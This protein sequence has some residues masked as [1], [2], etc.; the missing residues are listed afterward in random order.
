M[1]NNEI[2]KVQRYCA[3]NTDIGEEYA[4]TGF[5]SLQSVLEEDNLRRILEELQV[6]INDKIPSGQVPKTQAYFDVVGDPNSLKQIQNLDKHSQYFKDLAGPM[7]FQAIAESLMGEKATLVNLQY[8]NK[9]PKTSKETPPH[10]DG[11]YFHIKPNKAITMWLSLDFATEEN[12][13]LVYVKESGFK[14]MRQH[15]ASGILGFSQKCTDY[16]TA[17]DLQNEVVMT[18]NPGDLVAHNSFVLHRAGANTTNDKQRRAL[19][20][21][22]YAADVVRDEEKAAAYQRLLDETLAREGRI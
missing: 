19:G 5:V 12:G 1:A 8:F 6:V 11:F 14:G 2:A 20:F 21:V 9:P 3:R 22:Y 15:Q 10:Q 16:G 17:E 13:C 7:G 18:A 4:K